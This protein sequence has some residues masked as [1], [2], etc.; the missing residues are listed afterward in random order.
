MNVKLIIETLKNITKVCPVEKI[1]IYNSEI[2][3]V[4]KST[5]ILDIL[6]FF[7]NHILYQFK[8]LTCISGVDYPTNKHR[9]KLVYELLS[10]RY[11]SRIR[12]KI[13]THELLTIDSCDKLF[14]TGGWYECEI[15]D[16]FGVFFKNHSNLKRILT[17]YGFEGYPLRKDFP[18]SGFIE[19]RYNEIQ[20]R[21]ITEPI[22][23]AQEYRTFKFLSPWEVQ[24]NAATTY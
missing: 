2:T 3:V 22:E 17:D 24:E 5:L 18:L 7:K 1:Q 6:L 23:L 16:M 4:V 9:F 13:F 11:N 14:L 12:I 20:K 21:V 8:I 19:M 10:I 15:W